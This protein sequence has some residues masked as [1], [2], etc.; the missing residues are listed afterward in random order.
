MLQRRDVSGEELRRRVKAKLR[1]AAEKDSPDAQ[2]FLAGIHAQKDY[3]NDYEDI[4]AKDIV[5]VEY[6][7]DLAFK[8]AEDNPGIKLLPESIEHP[9]G[10]L[11][12]MAVEGSFHPAMLEIMRYMKTHEMRANI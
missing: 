1:E 11:P 10:S 12:Q 9:V 2:I 6:Y 8:N 5:K 3:G 7:M 4:A